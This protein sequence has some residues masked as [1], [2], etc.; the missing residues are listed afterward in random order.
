MSVPDK[1]ARKPPGAAVASILRPSRVSPGASRLRLQTLVRLRWLAVSGQLCAVL[2]VYFG[3]GYP[4]P[5]GLCLFAVAVSAW[6]NI[7]LSVRYRAN[8]RLRNRYAAM[9]LAYDIVQLAGLLYLTGGLRNPFSFLFLVPAT[10]SAATLPMKRTLPLGLLTL[11]LATVL[12]FFHLPLPW[13]GME[14]LELP[15]LYVAGIW[16]ALV[17]G[18]GFLGIYV[19]RI[20]QE[21]RRMS[22]ALTATEM[23]LAHEQQLSALDGLAAAAAHELGT[24]LATIALVAK[25]LKRELADQPALAEDLDL[26]MSQTARCREILSTLTTRDDPHDRV[27]GRMKLG[28]MLEAVVEPLRGEK[29]IAV[30][31]QAEDGARDGDRREP[32]IARSPGVLYGIANLIDNA[33][34]FAETRVDVTAR[35][36]ADSVA[37]SIEDDGPGFAQE[38]IDKLGEPYVTTRPGRWPSE[39][40]ETGAHEGMGLGFFIA[41]TLL[42]RSGAWVALANR[43]APDHGAIVRILWPRAQIDTAH[44]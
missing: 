12:A 11:V 8:L 33:L 2:F 23:V 41:K 24:P 37:V 43:P 42:E 7:L 22:E 39:V 29:H 3:L 10:V 21:T 19:W 13:A 4:L 35:W 30:A 20:S 27:F 17:C 15:G 5:L 9:L 18:L 26:L 34:D 40:S 44:S 38:V 25:E 16:V 1:K 32:L 31:A 28:I 6:L 14:E 36:D